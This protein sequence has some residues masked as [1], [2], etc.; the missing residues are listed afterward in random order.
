MTVISTLTKNRA[1]GD[2][3]EVNFNFVFKI[4]NDSD[5]EVYL[6][7][8]AGVETLQ[9]LNVDYT[10]AIDPVNEGGTVTLT[11]APTSAQ[12]VLIK[13]VLPLTQPTDI[14][15]VG[16]LREEQ[17]E[18]E[19]DRGRMIDQQ[20]QEAIDRAVKQVV[21]SLVADLV[22]P[23]PVTGKFLHA[24]STTELDWSA[25]TSTSYAGTISRGNDTDK[26]ASPGAGDI[27]FAIDTG[28]VYICD[29]AGV[30]SQMTATTTLLT[31]SVP[32]VA[33]GFVV[34]DLLKF[35]GGVYAKA[36]ADSAANA[37]LVGIVTEVVDSD[38]FTLTLMGFFTG[39]SGLV[40]GSQYFLSPSSAGGYTTT[41]PSTPG[42]V[43][44]PV[45]IAV[46]TTTGFFANQRGDL[47]AAPPA[48]ILPT[49][50]LDGGV[51]SNN[52]SDPT[53]DI[54]FSQ[55]YARSDDDAVDIATA[56][57]TK[58]IDAVW[59]TGT[60]AGML[61]TGTIGASPVLV[62]FYAIGDSTAVLTDDI[63]ATKTLGS[64]TMPAGYNKKRLLGHRRWTG[65][66]WVKFSTVGKGRDKWVYLDTPLQLLSAGSATSFTDVNCAAFVNGAVCKLIDIMGQ[67]NKNSISTLSHYVRLNGSSITGDAVLFHR[68]HDDQGGAGNPNGAS[69][70]LVSLDASAIY[71]YANS[72]GGAAA[73]HYLRGFL[74]SL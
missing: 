5:L 42:Q 51:P 48:T 40:A 45:F 12:D 49:N 8:T 30:W 73:N 14:P 34:G 44:K 53:N 41:E 6:V 56:A 38:T 60:N 20:L 32:Q 62:Y 50:Y 17:I 61:D 63:V 46:S 23:A 2:G 69:V 18:K 57:M 25:I 71:E 55:V 72:N 4:F 68:D 16:T 10:V 26:A 52:G 22:F 43:I 59:A 29:I 70:G 27:Y 28:R 64:P 66:A 11:V 35:S 13:R 36:Q 7:D 21:T 74:E 3:I 39:F 65:S 1:D 15:A 19:L 47:I 9:T 31:K 33:H 24:N 58:Q 37:R 67:I 54:D